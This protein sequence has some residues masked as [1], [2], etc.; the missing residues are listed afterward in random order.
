MPRLAKFLKLSTVDKVL[1]LQCLFVVVLVRIG[2]SLFSY[3]S[4]QRVLRP[5]KKCRTSVDNGKA[6]LIVRA[7]GSASRLVPRASCLT[8]ALAA[9]FIL[10][11][12]GFSS[13]IRVGVAIL[14]EGKF[15]A[16]AW[17]IC[18]GRVV[19]GGTAAEIRRYAMLVDLNL[20][21]S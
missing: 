13:Q 14:E 7:V 1:A 10:A 8:Q 2:L 5:K 4:L 6:D 15:V 16:H 12:A 18:E 21:G 11:Q 20:G 9:Q 19:M 17:L 3:R